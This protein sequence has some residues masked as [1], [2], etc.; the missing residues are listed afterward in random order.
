MNRRHNAFFL[1]ALLVAAIPHIVQAMNCTA[2]VMFERNRDTTVSGELSASFSDRDPYPQRR[3]ASVNVGAFGI[4][5][6]A[7][8]DNTTPYP[9]Y[10][11]VPHTRGE[12]KLTNV[13]FSSAGTDPIPAS[14]N[15][16]FDGRFNLKDSTGR[17]ALGKIIITATIDGATF[18]GEI[19]VCTSSCTQVW[20]G[21]CSGLSGRI[22][23]DARL[24]TPEVMVPV[25]TPVTVELT[26]DITLTVDLNS[27]AQAEAVFNNTYTFPH[28]GPVFNVP[29]GVTVNSEQS[30]IVDNLYAAGNPVPVLPY[31][32][33]ALKALYR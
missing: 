4:R 7:F 29:A 31:N 28:D 9:T 21:L 30:I 2:R 22:Y 24:L 33:G 5:G 20:L 3:L 8:V 27:W 13:V 11:S 25:N 23:N 18:E 10:L 16:D 1:A 26:L 32:W 6:Y 17:Y 15:L 12:L 14:L 19:H